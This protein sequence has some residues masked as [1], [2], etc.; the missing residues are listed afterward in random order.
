MDIKMKTFA[1]QHP[2]L[3]F[4]L[5]SVFLVGFMIPFGLWVSTRYPNSIDELRQISGGRITTNI[6]YELPFM[7]RVEGGIAWLLFFM[8]QPVTP[9]IAALITSYLIGRQ[10]VRDLVSR[11]RFWSTDVGWKKGVLIWLALPE[12]QKKLIPMRAAIGVGCLWALWHIPIK[13]EELTNGIPMFLYFYIC[14]TIRCILLS[15]IISYFYNRLGGSIF[16]AIALHGIDNDSSGITGG[17]C[18][19]GG[20]LV[21][22]IEAAKVYSLMELLPPLIFVVVI[23]VIDAKRLFEKQGVKLPV[24]QQPSD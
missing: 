10:R 1:K 9:L 4:W 16:I 21:N 24:A 11:W 6:L 18:G 17:F 3:T 22:T 13:I 8:A 15:I 7:L 5:I 12:L 2:V 14:F 20:D 23:L 19:I